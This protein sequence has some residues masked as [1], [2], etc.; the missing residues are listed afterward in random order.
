MN[1]EKKQKE[2]ENKERKKKMMAE[3]KL[4]LKKKISAIKIQKFWKA[5][6]RRR[7][8]K[9]KHIKLIASARILQRF[10][11]KSMVVLKEKK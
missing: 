5:R 9:L 3:R 10:F 2:E 4:L 11:K 7:N 1:K 8:R 6:M